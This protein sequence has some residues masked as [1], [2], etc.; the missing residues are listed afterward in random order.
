MGGF[1]KAVCDPRRVSAAGPIT[2][3]FA[4]GARPSH[5]MEGSARHGAP[6]KSMGGRNLPHVGFAPRRNDPVLHQGRT[7]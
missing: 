1:L 3:G 2:G 4:I 6:P 7:H 5:F